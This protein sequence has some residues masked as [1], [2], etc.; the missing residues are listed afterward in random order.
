MA[1]RVMLVCDLCGRPAERSITMRVDGRNL[2]IDVCEPDTRMLTKSARPARRGRPKTVLDAAA[3][4]QRRQRRAPSSKRKAK[5]ST[6]RRKPA[7]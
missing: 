2:V 6:R 3:V 4:N 1:E 7:A 5:A